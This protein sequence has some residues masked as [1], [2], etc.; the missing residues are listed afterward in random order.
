MRVDGLGPAH[1]EL[2]RLNVETAARR[3]RFAAFL[4]FD[5]QRENELIA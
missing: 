1:A 4:I 3:Q 5:R 2:V